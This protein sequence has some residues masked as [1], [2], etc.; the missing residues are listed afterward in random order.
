[1]KLSPRDAP[2]YFAR[3]DAARPGLLIYGADGM[4]VA[5]RRQQV[6]KALI[7][8]QGEEEMRLTRMTAADL[9]KDPAMLLDAVKAQGFFPGPPR[10]LC[11]GGDRHGRAHCDRGTG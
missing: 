3:P 7:G 5:L 4:R 11:R 1:M 8:P 6:I 9:R 10:G 2:G